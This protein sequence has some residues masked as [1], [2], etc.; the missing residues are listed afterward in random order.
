MGKE[1]E[2]VKILLISSNVF[3][4]PPPS[5]GGLE[6]VVHNLATGLRDLGFK[7]T[8]A[9]PKGSTPPEKVE[10]INTGRFGFDNPE[11]EAYEKY[12]DKLKEFDV[13]LDHSWKFYSVQ[14][15]MNDSSL[16]IIKTLHGIRPFGS[17]PP[18]E[19]PCLVGVSKWHSQYIRDVYQCEAEYA[20]NGIDLSQYPYCEDKEDYLLFLARMSYYKGALQFINICKKTGMKGILCGSDRYVEDQSFVWEVMRRCDGKQIQYYGEV[21]H[22][23]KIHLLKHAKALVSPLLPEYYEIFGLNLVEALAC[24]T[25]VVCT[26]QGACREIVEDGVSG[27]VVPCVGAI[28]EAIA[29]LDSISPKDC[30]AQAEKFSLQEMAHRYSYLIKKLLNEGEW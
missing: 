6:L 22:D 12:K 27:F 21:S 1:G 11:H 28:P 20:Y 10:W 19:K 13:I 23:L 17:K 16:K 7:V 29:H 9:A 8:I 4:T 24:G 18:V 15:K 26:D 30:R 3:P 2:N 25:P 14:S 5:Y